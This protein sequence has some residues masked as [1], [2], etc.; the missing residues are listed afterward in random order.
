MRPIVLLLAL[1]LPALPQQ[2]VRVLSYNIHHGEGLDAKIDLPRI[3]G[4]IKSVDPDLVALQEVDIRTQRSGGVDQLWELARLTGMQPV[5]GQTISHQGG[6]Y[7]NAVLARRPL[8]GFANHALP[9]REP[10]GVIDGLVAPPPG[11]T[12]LAAF[13]FLATHLDLNETDRLGAAA[14]IEQVVNSWPEAAP[15]ILAGDMNAVPESKPVAALSRVWI[16]AEGKAP[17]LTSPAA[18]PRRQIDYIFVHPANR[19]RVVEIRV[20]D[21]A[22]ASDH[23]PLFAVVELLPAVSNPR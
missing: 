10:R 19:W 4:V 15:A 17:L 5:F 9:G 20:L 18:A 14:R 11:A 16:A 7:G 3:A 8:A 6:L 23:R 22:V 21:E 1:C 13:H 12:G 2:V